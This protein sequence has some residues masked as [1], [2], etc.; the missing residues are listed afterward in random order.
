MSPEQLQGEPL[1]LRADIFS[2][3]AC[4]F[5]MLTGKPPLA[6]KSLAQIIT[7]RMSGQVESVRPFRPD[8]SQGSVELLA[9]MMAHDPARRP[10]DYRELLRRID[11]LD[12]ESP[13]SRS[14]LEFAPSSAVSTRT[15]PRAATESI[16]RLSTRARLPGRKWLTIG[17]GALA[18]ILILVAVAS[19]S[20]SPGERDLKPSGRIEELFNGQN[21]NQWKPVSGGWSQGKNQEGAQVLQGRGLV[22]RSI[23]GLDDAGEPRPVEH[24]RLMFVVDPHEAAAVEVQFD[25]AADGRDEQCLF[26]RIDHQGCILGRRSGAQATAITAV[27]RDHAAGSGVLQAVEIER[28]SQGWWALVDGELLGSV[29]FVHATPAAE[30]RLLAEGGFAWFSDFTFEE[31]EPPP[32]HP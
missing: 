16:A 10:A 23:L 28:Q 26:V 18:A 8:V 12:L 31:L 7:E 19:R 15:W 3:G 4:A 1:D 21:I 24:Y 25:L 30:F 20:R 11:A 6:G 29:P 32:D 22:R 14:T 9:D 2:L 13:G 17:V 27:L 5:Q